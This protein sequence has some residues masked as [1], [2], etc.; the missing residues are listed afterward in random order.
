MF[1]RL[2]KADVIRYLDNRQQLGFNVISAVILTQY[3]FAV[4]SVEGGNLALID[5]DP[6]KPNEAY[7]EY[8]DWVIEQA[9]SRGMYMALVATWGDKVNQKGDIGPVIFTPENAYPY[10]L[11]LGQRYR[12]AS[13][14]I[15]V[16][17]GDRNPEN[18]TELKLWEEMGRGIEEGAGTTA[19][20]TYHPR[21]QRSSS[22]FFQPD[23]LVDFNMVQSGHNLRDTPT[24]ELVGGGYLLKPIKPIL[25]VEFNYEGGAVARNRDNGFFDDYDVRKQAYRSVFAGGAGITYGHQSIWQFYAPLNAAGATQMQHLAKLML[26]RPYFDRI[27]DQKLL[28]TIQ[29][30][31][32][33]G[34]AAHPVATRAADGSYAFVYVP[35]NQPVEIDFSLLSGTMIRAWW[36]DPRTGESV[37]VGTFSKTEPRKLL[38]PVSYQDWVLVLDDAERG[39]GAP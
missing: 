29:N 32:T 26:A 28:L 39:F 7:F 4:P 13:N 17:G 21:G 16:L 25:D 30:A 18:E 11:F 2:S 20:I 19:M 27:P 34:N 3:S 9:A 23:T 14:V 24:W 35:T 31:E 33:A 5:N 22:Q 15:W 38:P 10:G 36:F 12:D 1:T 6:L 37:E 8:V